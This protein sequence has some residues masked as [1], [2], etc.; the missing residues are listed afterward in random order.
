MKNIFPITVLVLL[1]A[2][3]VVPRIYAGTLLVRY[4]ILFWD[5]H[6]HG[7]APTMVA[8]GSKYLSLVLVIVALTAALQKGSRRFLWLFVMVVSVL[9]FATITRL[10]KNDIY[11][12]IDSGQRLVQQVEAYHKTHGKYPDRLSDLPDVPRTG[13]AE[14]RRFY[15]A[16]ARN[17]LD[18]KGA[19]FPNTSAYLGD[20]P[21]VICVPLV[22][23]GTLVYRPAEKYSDLPVYPQPHGWYH[24]TR[25]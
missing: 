25:D 2:V 13:L 8:I 22:P 23:G 16:S 14:K 18:D 12:V 1:A 5:T 6:G 3:L 24:T 9:S 11:R 20:A 21:Y 4:D 10:P 7:Y 15:Y 17:R 19:W